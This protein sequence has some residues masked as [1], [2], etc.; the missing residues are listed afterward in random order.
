M[1]LDSQNEVTEISTTL[2]DPGHHE[3]QR[4]KAHGAFQNELF[5]LNPK[6]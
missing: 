2:Q 6:P 3:P 4:L 5:I 1:V